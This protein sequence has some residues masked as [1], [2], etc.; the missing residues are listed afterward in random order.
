MDHVQA[1]NLKQ[2]NPLKKPLKGELCVPSDKSISHRAAIFGALTFET[3]NI[4]N[5][6]SGQDCKSTLEVLKNLG[7]EI[8]QLSEKDIA[9]SAKNKFS[10]PNNILDAGNSGT[11]MR[12]MAGVMAGSDFYSVITGDESLRKRPMS[13]VISPLGQ[14]GA[15]I[16]ARVNN[17]KAPLTIIGSKLHA[18]NYNSPIASA[19]VKSALLLAGL[20]AEGT[21][22]VTEPYK[23]RDHTERMLNYLGA[24]IKIEN[25]S[26]SI[27]KSVLEPKFISIP[28]DISS[29]AFFMVAGA[30]IPDSE[31]IL[32]EVGLNPT[33]TGIIDIL[34]KMGAEI[35]VLNE[36]TACGEEVGDIKV[37]YSDLKGIIIEGSDIPRLIDE[38]PV[39]AVAATQ[40]EGE[41]VI[42]GA[43]DLRHK[44]SDRISAICNELTKMGA[45]IK[46]TPDGF[47]VEGK[48]RLRGDCVLETYH[49]HRIA[50]SGYIAALIAE[51][52]LYIDGFDWVNISFPTFEKIFND[53]GVN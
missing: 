24:D 17:T 3:V 10:E 21:T 33:R 42:K 36:R 26:V 37:C 38:L 9:V 45:K 34:R 16:F 31:I 53:L 29:A 32:R 12:L 14:M 27:K 51:K 40:A 44:E 23:S 46:E 52:P 20:S 15:K 5:F 39:I 50:M 47:I 2:V 11:T 13:R 6:S 49:D 35:S 28:G 41:T 18:I 22:A 8:K 4:S 25:N 19:Q 7:V 48:T 30:I 43:E 1:K